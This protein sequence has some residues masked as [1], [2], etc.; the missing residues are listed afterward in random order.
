MIITKHT[1]GHPTK[2]RRA[3]KQ[4]VLNVRRAKS[5]LH[6]TVVSSNGRANNS[7]TS[8]GAAGGSVGAGH[9][10]G[11]R[12]CH[13]VLLTHIKGP[14]RNEPHGASQRNHS[15]RGNQSGTA[16]TAVELAADG[17]ESLPV[18]LV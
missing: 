6:T 16:Q 15:Q 1:R 11:A 10:P 18:T 13:S 8:H 3:K 14:G 12:H 4:Q 2:K 5:Q 9:H 7:P 17:G